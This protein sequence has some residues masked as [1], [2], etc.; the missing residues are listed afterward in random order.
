ML[1]WFDC[2]AES[3]S[4]PVLFLQFHNVEEQVNMGVPLGILLDEFSMIP[5]KMLG[6]VLRIV[7][8]F[9]LSICEFNFLNCVYHH[10]NQI[11]RRIQQLH[12]N[13]GR[14]LLPSL[15]ILSGDPYQVIVIQC[16]DGGISQ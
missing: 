7:E 11:L 2:W 13:M 4:S 5:A 14:P 3:G 10:P 16:V 6:Q 15:F 1:F 8:I 12:S 9:I